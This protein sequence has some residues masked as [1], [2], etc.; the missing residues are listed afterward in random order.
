VANVKNWNP[1]FSL[2]EAV[3]F[4]K[5]PKAVLFEIARQF[6]MRL[7]DNFT[8]E[9]AFAVMC[10]EWRLLHENGIVPQHPTTIKSEAEIIA[11]MHPEI[12]R[13]YLAQK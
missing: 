13:A 1:G 7:G 6:A 4:K 8:T 9:S 5:C 3:W 11:K 10:E 12:L 2:S